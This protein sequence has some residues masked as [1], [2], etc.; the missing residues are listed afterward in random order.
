[1][2]L[3]RRLIGIKGGGGILPTEVT[4]YP[5]ADS[6]V[7]S[8]LPNNNYGA[9]E[10]L[11]HYLYDSNIQ[12]SYLRFNL[13]SI[14]AGS[15]ILEARLGLHDY[16]N[17]P[18]ESKRQRCRI[19]W[20]ITW[21]EMTITWNNK[22]GWDTIIND[23]WNV[24]NDWFNIIGIDL[25]QKVQACLPSGKISFFIEAK[26]ATTGGYQYPD[27]CSKETTYPNW[28]PY[29]YVKFKPGVSA[30][31]PTVTFVSAGAGSGTT[32]N[33]TPSYQGRRPSPAA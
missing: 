1:M 2:S 4:L 10:R 22:P 3:L 12:Y 25:K 14:P 6:Y 32:G 18:F 31:P 24:Y 8:D 28:K 26:D 15:E 29:L 33:P 5:E 16:P 23:F 21:G 13:S 19:V 30:E 11:I 17:V 20:N 7:K 27:A 9:E